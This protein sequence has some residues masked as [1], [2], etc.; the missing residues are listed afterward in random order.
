MSL[1]ILMISPTELFVLVGCWLTGAAIIV[2]LFLA[3]RHRLQMHEE[4]GT[5]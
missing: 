2:G 3:N 1:T 4:A 5:E